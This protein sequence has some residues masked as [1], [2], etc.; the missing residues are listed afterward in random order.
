MAGYVTACVMIID[1]EWITGL[2]SNEVDIGFVPLMRVF[3]ASS[4]M[5]WKS[6]VQESSL[7]SDVETFNASSIAW[8]QEIP[9]NQVTTGIEQ[10][11]YPFK[12]VK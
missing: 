3:S 1:M 10:T 5:L 11:M 8:D 12:K 2:G 7:G 6:D 9:M 4:S